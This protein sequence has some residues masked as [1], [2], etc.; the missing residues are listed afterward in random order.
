MRYKHIVV[1]VGRS[2]AK[3]W[4][5]HLRGGAPVH[6]RLRGRELAG[7]ATA[8]EGDPDLRERYLARFPRASTS[9]DSDPRPVLVR[10]AVL[11][12]PR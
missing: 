1:Y 10:I 6:V 3:V 11:G 7:T 4:W 8:V 12:A 5:R 2:Q 9:L